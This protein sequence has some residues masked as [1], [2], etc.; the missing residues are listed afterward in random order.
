MKSSEIAALTPAARESLKIR[1]S[2]KRMSEPEIVA[3]WYKSETPF[4]LK[5]IEDHIR[6]RW[7]WA[8]AQ[9]LAL[10]PYGEVVSSL[11]SEFN[12]SVAQARNDIRN[13]RHAFGNL[14]EV[15]KQVH[16]ERAIEMSLRAYKIAEADKDADGM[17]KATKVYIMAAGLDKDD[18]ETVDIE[19]LMKERIYVEAL[20]P[21]VRN[22]L[23]NFLQ[24]SNGVIDAS[25]LFE[26]VYAAKEGEAFTDYETVIPGE[27]EH[28]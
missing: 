11:M 19:K 23:L 3:F 16:R 17:A 22:F 21:I 24:N 6:Q 18:T 27:D 26:A 2:L 28:E 10:S 15:P 12:I 13:M 7:D 1:E 8:K 25:K 5:P 4:D 14:D 9:F 20:D